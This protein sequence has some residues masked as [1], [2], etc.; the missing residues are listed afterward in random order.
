MAKVQLSASVLMTYAGMSR[1]SLMVSGVMALAGGWRLDGGG[2]GPWPPSE[3][4]S[5]LVG[6]GRCGTLGSPKAIHHGLG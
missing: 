3:Q 6:Y 2:Q 4:A 1:P 5:W